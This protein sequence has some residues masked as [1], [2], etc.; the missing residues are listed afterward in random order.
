MGNLQNILI[1]ILPFTCVLPLCKLLFHLLCLFE[2]HTTASS[3][4]ITISNSFAKRK[5][6]VQKEEKFRT[7]SSI[8]VFS[9]LIFQ[10]KVT[11]FYCDKIFQKV[12]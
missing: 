12:H 10:M 7:I 4:E 8:L 11:T 1:N 2:L 5:Q 9:S 3:S 6:E